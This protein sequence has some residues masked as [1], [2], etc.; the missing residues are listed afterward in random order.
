MISLTAVFVSSDFPSNIAAAFL[1]STTASLI[2]KTT[3]LAYSLFAVIL[4]AA[5][6]ASLPLS[7]CSGVTFAPNAFNVPPVTLNSPALIDN[8]S[9]PSSVPPLIFHFA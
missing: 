2:F 4:I 6:V 9:E 7:N 5:P 3:D 8:A 1:L